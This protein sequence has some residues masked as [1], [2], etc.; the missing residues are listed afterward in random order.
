MDPA[1]KCGC[2]C[3]TSPQLTGRVGHLF[4]EGRAQLGKRQAATG[5]DFA[6]AVVGLGVERGI[7]EFQRFGFLKRNGLAFI[8]TPLG[9]F[10]VTPKPEVNLLFD[11]D[12]W[13]ESLRRA[14]RGQSAPAG[15]TKALRLIDNAILEF[16]AHGGSSRLQEVLVAA[17]QAERWLASSR[18]KSSIRPL[19][20]LSPDWLTKS[21]DE[22]PEFR[23][24]AA[25]ASIQ[26][27]EGVGSVRT[28]LEAVA[29]Q[30]RR[31]VWTANDTSVVWR[32][33]NTLRS[34]AA[35]LERRCL[36]T[37]MGRGRPLPPTELSKPKPVRLL[38]IDQME[39]AVC[40]CHTR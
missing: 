26:G 18:Q 13:L 33:G 3:G 6:R 27:D 31:W 32:F 21:D 25:L 8:A 20:G 29:F 40:H 11:L 4:G 35:V 24:A 12:P 36:E 39:H 19:A 16:C 17:G 30:T 28:N 34:M 2:R 23:I 22:S 1:P 10:Q 9:R 5:T 37:R 38:A 7:T 14:A 15:L